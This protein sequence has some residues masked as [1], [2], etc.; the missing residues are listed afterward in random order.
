MWLQFVYLKAALWSCLELEWNK[1]VLFFQVFPRY[2]GPDGMK[3]DR[4]F[5]YSR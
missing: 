2:G 4:K 3:F 5:V 1:C